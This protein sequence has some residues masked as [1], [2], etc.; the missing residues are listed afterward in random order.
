MSD[1]RAMGDRINQQRALWQTMRAFTPP[2]GARQ[3]VLNA[4]EAKLGRPRGRSLIAPVLAAAA[5]CAVIFFWL[6]PSGQKPAVA[7]VVA[8]SAAEQGGTWLGGGDRLDPGSIR[9]AEA[10]HLRVD[11]GRARVEVAGPAAVEF[12]S[13][14]LVLRH[15]EVTVDGDLEV[16]GPHCTA[17]VQGRSA[18]SVSDARLQVHVFS[19]S[20]QLSTADVSCRVIDMSDALEVWAVPHRSPDPRPA[21]R[22]P[23]AVQANLP[24]T[25]AR[26]ERPATDDSAQ[27]RRQPLARPRSPSPSL[28]TKLDRPPAAP[29]SALSRQVRAYWAAVELRSS[30]PHRALARLRALLTTWP[31]TAL[32]PEIEFAIFDT[33]IELGRTAEARAQARHILEQLPN[34]PRAGELRRASQENA[35][36]T[37]D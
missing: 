14:T 34:T 26:P 19:G 31:D 12:R 36:S 25:P 35:E 28:S 18:V 1:R 24:A 8:A 4:V 32:R 15:G 10:G 29:P 37:D 6:V 22:L 16:E 2:A 23:D 11:T 20:A 3:R 17:R 13:R 27:P 21:A 7:R 33:L 5:A 9:V 30:R